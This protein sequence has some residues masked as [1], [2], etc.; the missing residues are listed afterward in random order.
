M[1]CNYIYCKYYVD[2]TES[3]PLATLTIVISMSIGLCSVLL[4]PI[5][6][7]LITYKGDTVANI[8]IDRTNLNLVINCKDNF[9]QPFI[10][11]FYL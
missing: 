6:I 11:F 7:F 5:D 9:N 10:Q 4:I 3:Y 2:P 8:S 1:L